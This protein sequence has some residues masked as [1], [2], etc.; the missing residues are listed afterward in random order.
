MLRAPLSVNG[1][2]KCK[3]LIQKDVQDV[4]QAS[5]EANAFLAKQQDI[6]EEGLIKEMLKADSFYDHHTTLL[7][8][9]HYLSDLTDDILFDI[10][11]EVINLPHSM[12]FSDFTQEHRD[13]YLRL[14]FRCLHSSS[15]EIPNQ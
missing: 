3:R 5:E 13:T 15:A 12:P 7:S 14:K 6:L 9:C 8:A 10:Y 1:A 11:H 4:I 2:I